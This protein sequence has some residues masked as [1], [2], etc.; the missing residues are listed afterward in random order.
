VAEVSDI[1]GPS[2]ASGGHW[3]LGLS[4]ARNTIRHTRRNVATLA[5]DQAALASSL[6]TFQEH[7]G[8][9]MLPL[10]AAQT[11]GVANSIP[12]CPAA[13]V[14]LSWS[15]SIVAATAGG[16]TVAGQRGRCLHGLAYGVQSPLPPPRLIASQLA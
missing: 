7:E 6:R 14:L 8:A 11:L 9:G 4:P 1:D 2:G 16:G 13:T 5:V 12:L 15:G 3:N 10:Y